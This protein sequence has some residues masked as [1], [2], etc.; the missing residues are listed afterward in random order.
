[1]N[2]YQAPGPAPKKGSRRTWL[3]VLVGIVLFLGFYQLMQP[4][5][6]RYVTAEELRQRAQHRDAA[7]E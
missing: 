1:M 4:G 2:P 6:R 3:F 7:S 5:E